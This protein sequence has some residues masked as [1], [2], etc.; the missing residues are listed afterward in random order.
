MQL[1]QTIKVAHSHQYKQISSQAIIDRDES[2]LQ[3]KF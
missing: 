3:E 2:E 1:T